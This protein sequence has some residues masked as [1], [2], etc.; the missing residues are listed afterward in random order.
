MGKVVKEFCNILNWSNIRRK[1]IPKCRGTYRKSPSPST[2]VLLLSLR[3]K[4]KFSVE[5]CLQLFNSADRLIDLA[6]PVIIDTD[7][8]SSARKKAHSNLALLK[9]L[10]LHVFYTA[11]ANALVLWLPTLCYCRDQ[12]FW[13][14]LTKVLN[15]IYL[16]YTV[17]GSWYVWAY[18]GRIVLHVS[19]VHTYHTVVCMLCRFLYIIKLYVH[20]YVSICLHMID[21]F[22]IPLSKTLTQ[23]FNFGTA[24]V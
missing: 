24:I 1:H 13:L 8:S 18:S 12:H 16:Q 3:S 19:T 14:I 20:N 23:L 5:C 11:S 17:P 21:I 9:L 4:S 10:V 6:G 7:C 15:R 22:W 2:G